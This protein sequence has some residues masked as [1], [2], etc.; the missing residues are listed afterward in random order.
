LFWFWAKRNP[1]Q[2]TYYAYHEQFVAQATSHGLPIGPDWLIEALGLVQLDPAGAYEGP[3]SRPDNRVEIHN[4]IER[5]GAV[6]FRRLVL[7]ER[8]GWIVEQQVA[9]SFGRILATA[10][11]SDHRFY[12]E[13]R[14][15]LPHRVQ[16]EIPSAELSFLLDVGRYLVNQLNTDA[17]TFFE[18]PNNDGDFVNLATLPS[19]LFTP[20]PHPAYPSPTPATY[21]P[22][23]SFRPNYRSVGP[24]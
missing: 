21:D 8:H 1:S 10:R 20:D 6:Y 4:R 12:E 7:D 9:D 16:I 18:I 17:A 2:V 19:G 13:A 15:S 24:R 3:I 14:A 5:N 23:T 11:C 22:R